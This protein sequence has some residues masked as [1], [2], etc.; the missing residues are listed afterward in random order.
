MLLPLTLAL[1]LPA[2]CFAAIHS[3][4]SIYEICAYHDPNLKTLVAFD[5][6]DTLVI[7]GDPAFQ[8]PNFK[9][10]HAAAFNALIGSLTAEEKYLTFTLPLFGPSQLIELDA[11]RTL[12][13]LQ[14]LSISEKSP[15]RMRGFEILPAIRSIFR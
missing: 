7:L 14:E 1:T 10:H 8:R 9:H 11:S 4:D 3:I 2:A 15:W 12:R 5:L 6:D 13:R